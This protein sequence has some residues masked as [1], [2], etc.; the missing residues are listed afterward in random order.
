MIRT[1]VIDAFL[2]NASMEDGAN[3]STREL[4]REEQMNSVIVFLDGVEAIVSTTVRQS[5]SGFF[6][7]SEFFFF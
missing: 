3:T 2:Q 6:F 4:E 5:F 7:F 1:M